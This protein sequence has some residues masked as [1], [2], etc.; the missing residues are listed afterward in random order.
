MI[1]KPALT[2]E[3]WKAIATQ[4]MICRAELSKLAG[5]V[6]GHIQC[7]NLDVIARAHTKVRML[8]Y[9]LEVEMFDQTGTQDTSIFDPEVR[10]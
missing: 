3:E 5:M 9:S 10:R 4:T 2:I 6:N 8:R 1:Q 7:K